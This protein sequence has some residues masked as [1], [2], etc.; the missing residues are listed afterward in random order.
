MTLEILRSPTSEIEIVQ[1]SADQNWTRLPSFQR[2]W[3]GVFEEL[4]ESSRRVY[5]KDAAQFAEWLASWELNL[6]TVGF[7]DLLHYKGEL[8]RLYPNKKT[9]AR[10]LTV[11]KRLVGMAHSI[12][13]RPDNPAAGLKSFKNTG[14]GES[15]ETSHR[16]LTKDEARA[17][18]AQVDT[19]K[20]IGKRDYALLTFLIRTGL[21]RAECAA[22]VLG[23]LKT[24]QG[25]HIARIRHGK[26]DKA[27]TVKIPVDVMRK[28]SDYLDATARKQAGPSAPLFITFSKGDKATETA[29]VGKDIER[30]VCRYAKAAGLTGLTPHGLRASFVTLTLEGGAKLEQVQYAVGHA[31]PRTTERYQ[32]RKLNLDDNAVD[33]FKL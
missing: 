30:V 19:S 22:L 3:A 15:G 8:A 7:E 27:R 16:A 5:F 9:A 23:D 2:A 10:K 26:G 4:S 12:G 29:M 13:L 1:E 33:Y 21:R 20:L 14:P 24:E 31:D 32:R 17:L 18:F 25:H 28:I 6:L 11:A